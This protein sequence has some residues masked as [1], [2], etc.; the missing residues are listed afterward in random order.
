MHGDKIRL[1]YI[2]IILFF[3]GHK[4]KLKTN[5]LNR[6]IKHRSLDSAPVRKAARSLEKAKQEFMYKEKQAIVLFLRLGFA[7]LQL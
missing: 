5:R 3:K 1:I 4:I 2:C 6:Y 7:N